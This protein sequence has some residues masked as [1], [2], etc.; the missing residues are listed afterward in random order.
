MG[1]FIGMTIAGVIGFFLG[2]GTRNQKRKYE[3]L[4]INNTGELIVIKILQ[5]HFPRTS[6]YLLNNI[7]LPLSNSDNGTVQIDHILINEY[8]VFVIETKHYSGWI[9]GKETDFKWTQ[10]FDNGKKFTF[11]N[12]LKQ[13]E[14]HINE[15]KKYF[16]SLESKDFKS[17]IVFTGKAEFKSMPINNVIE[18]IYLVDYIK[19]FKEKKLPEIAMER[20]ISS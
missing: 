10:S 19:K 5:E 2:K 8:G 3:T 4:D 13:N 7:T 16:P 1:S 14:F 11:L 15:L 9:F 18:S 12:P 17:I 6:N 20:I